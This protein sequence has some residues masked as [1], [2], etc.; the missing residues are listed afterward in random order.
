MAEITVRCRNYSGSYLRI[1]GDYQRTISKLSFIRA[2]ITVGAQKYSDIVNFGWRGLFHRFGMGIAVL[3]F[4]EKR[5]SHLCLSPSFRS[6]DMS[7]K[8]AAS[9]WYGMAFTKLVAESELSIPWLGHVD[10]L[11]ARGVLQ[12]M[13]GSRMRGDLAGRDAV[14]EW[15]VLEAKGRSNGY[16][17]TLVATAKGQA[18][19][20]ISINGRLPSTTSASIA[21]LDTTPIS[22]LLDDPHDDNAKESWK[23]NKEEFFHEY[24]RVIIEYIEYYRQNNIENYEGIEFIVAPLYLYPLFYHAQQP[25][26]IGLPKQIF[27]KPGIA[28]SFM[29]EFA[30]LTEKKIKKENRNNRDQDIGADGI[31]VAGYNIDWE[32]SK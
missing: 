3:P 14:G 10:S 1:N 24:Y 26:L 6:L 21:R 7:E 17:N 28:P 30:K 32:E 20:V 2:I 9:Y 29:A 5:G 16:G 19:R 4:L 22:V 12:I 25:L 15:H 27:D 11:W 8:A 18:A 13:S 31:L 23:I